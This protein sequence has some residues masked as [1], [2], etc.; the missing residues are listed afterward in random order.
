MA[1]ASV[2]VTQQ[3]IDDTRLAP[4]NIMLSDMQNVVNVGG[5]LQHRGHNGETPVCVC[6]GGGVA[7][8][9]LLL[10]LHEALEYIIQLHCI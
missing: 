10:R 6:V 1:A 5:D 7:F 3:L 8:L 9:S 2:G 4:E